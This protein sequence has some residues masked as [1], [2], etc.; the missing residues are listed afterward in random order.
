[1]SGIGELEMRILSELEEAGSEY[2]CSMLNTIILPAGLDQELDDLKLALR[3]LIARDLIKLE[4][5]RNPAHRRF[6]ENVFDREASL[7]VLAAVPMYMTFDHARRHWTWDRRQPI[8]E[9]I[10][11]DQGIIRAQEI[12]DERGYQW[13]REDE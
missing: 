2:V 7:A 3:H 13:W 9:I 11:S 5:Q 1:M 12:L 6:D 10:A 4:F 8:A